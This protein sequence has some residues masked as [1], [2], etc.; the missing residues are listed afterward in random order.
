MCTL[1]YR[2]TVNYVSTQWLE[3]YLRLRNR[4][5]SNRQSMPLKHAY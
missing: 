3:H 2:A 1:P 4:D 5:P